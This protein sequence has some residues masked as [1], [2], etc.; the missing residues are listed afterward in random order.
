[1]R[2]TL[3]ANVEEANDNIPQITKM[4]LDLL[5]TVAADFAE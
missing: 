1:M 4:P 2:A 3:A 5:V